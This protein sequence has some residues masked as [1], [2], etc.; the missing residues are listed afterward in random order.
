MFGESLLQAR[1]RTSKSAHSSSPNSSTSARRLPVSH[2]GVM[3]WVLAA[4]YVRVCISHGQ[5]P[6]GSPRDAGAPPVWPCRSRV[7]FDGTTADQATGASGTDATRRRQVASLH[8]PATSPGRGRRRVRLLRTRP[9]HPRRTADFVFLAVQ[10]PRGGA[11]PSGGRPRRR[12]PGSVSDRASTSQPPSHPRRRSD[13]QPP[14]P[15]RGGPR[16]GL[17]SRRL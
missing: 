17:R 10:R 1:S 13:R 6:A 7:V 8:A 5:Q 3:D 9:A 2:S 14:R 12:L 4:D 16:R 15:T 11:C